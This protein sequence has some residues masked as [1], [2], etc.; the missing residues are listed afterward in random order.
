MNQHYI[1]L[2]IN[3]VVAIAAMILI[4]L[5]IDIQTKR[6]LNRQPKGRL[7]SRNLA[8]K[9][10][11]LSEKKEVQ[12]SETL[13][14]A[15]IHLNAKEFYFRAIVMSTL[16]G[17]GAFVF[18]S[19][20]IP[21]YISILVTSLTVG[22][23]IYYP[24]HKLKIRLR[25]DELRKSIDLP[26]YLKILTTLLRTQPP[27][28][29]VRESIKYAPPIIQP[30]AETLLIEI[31]Q[32]P[33]TSIPY[34]NFAKNIGLR[35]AKQFMNLLYQSLDIS[36]KNS[37]DF[38]EK[39]NQMTDELENASSKRLALLQAN[40]MRKYGHILLICIVVLPLTLAL[41]TLLEI[42]NQFN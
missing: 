13:K 3:I 34:E 27:Y 2:A 9:L 29:A 14:K 19:I 7:V 35:Q 25:N 5:I 18:T 26:R 23:S 38:I 6:I 32:Y 8:Q 28:D 36:Q 10:I 33:K 11:M 41:V 37:R 20:Y 30:Y 40:S 15:K 12:F 21:G 31:T 1:F 17:T 16:T 42:F 39:L 24:F 4:W 22:F